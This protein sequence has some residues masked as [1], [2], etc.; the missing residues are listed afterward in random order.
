METE[1]YLTLGLLCGGMIVIS[2]M[3]I[4]AVLVHIRDDFHKFLE[5]KNQRR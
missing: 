1:M 3:G 4:C 5:S 2:L